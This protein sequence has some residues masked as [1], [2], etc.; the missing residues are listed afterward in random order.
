V[1]IENNYVVT[2]TTVYVLANS[3]TNETEIIKYIT[4]LT[5]L[6]DILQLQY[7]YVRTVPALISVFSCLPYHVMKGILYIVFYVD[8][9]T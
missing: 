2:Y 1:N 4:E 8:M 9:S 7:Y 5:C 6:T 3:F